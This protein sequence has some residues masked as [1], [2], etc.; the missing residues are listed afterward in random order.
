MNNIKAG[1]YERVSRDED[2][3]NYATIESQRSTNIEYCKENFGVDIVDS[4]E[5][6]NVSGY[7][8][9]RP[10]FK[11]LLSDIESGKINTIIAKDLSRIGRHNAYVL[12]FLE[13]MKKKNVRVI[14]ITDSYDSF[15]SDDDIIGI[16]TWYNEMYIKDI[17]K[18]IKSN[19]K[20]R[21]K[22]NDY[23]NA[24][25]YGYKIDKLTRKIVVDQECV[26]T[27]KRIYQLYID[28]DGYRKICMT[29]N[30][31]K[32]PTPSMVIQKQK[33]EEGK[34]YK[35]HVTDKW[36]ATMVMRMLRNDFYIGTLR[37]GKNSTKGIN[38]KNEKTEETEQYIFEENHE[39]IISKKDFEL[40]QE[41][42]Q[43]RTT[44]NYRGSGTKHQNL[45]S[46]FLFCAD[47]GSYMAALNKEGKNK[48]YICGS[49]NRMG[50]TGGC[51]THYI[52]DSRLK[53]GLKNY[54]EDVINKIGENLSR[55][56]KD[57]QQK[58]RVADNLENKL[59]KLQKE[60]KN[61][62]DE[63]KVM[64]GQ[65]I[66]DIA[67][68]PDFADVISES[69]YELEKEKRNKL[70][71]LNIQINDLQKMIADTS[72]YEEKLK[73]ALGV[74]QE[75]HQKEDFQKRDLEVLI[76]KIIIYEGGYFEISL[77]NEFIF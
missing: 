23:I 28:G 73:T 68:S 29:L 70:S 74:L 56:D 39:P 22:N 8:M 77:R 62:N 55:F 27:V 3:K 7:T 61:I 10:D 11:R 24:V 51:S 58:K 50:K 12:I 26:E 46:G 53:V 35:K 17:S 4:Y 60:A 67:K 57:V 13:E 37:L 18:K 16:K 75:M 63:L 5:D 30:D 21:M 19:L 40:V 32:V 59:D 33:N 48:S 36:D 72:Q 20:N 66:R 41:L 38:G 1:T 65:K 64:I 6:D 45:F 49:Y 43:K 25:P 2:K 47:C 44:Y 34:V 14:A 54:I 42:I 15:E 76:E 31:G 71:T 52:L 9:N 69:Y